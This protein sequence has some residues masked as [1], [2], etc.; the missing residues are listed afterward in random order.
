[1]RSSHLVLILIAALGVGCGSDVPP[2]VA[3]ASSQRTLVTGDVVG[4]LHP[5]RE[6]HVW[7]GI[8][9]AQPPVGELRWRAPLPPEPWEGVRN[10]ITAGNDCVQL[11]MTDPSKVTG[12]EDCLVLDVY[13]PKVAADAVPEGEDLKPVMVWI[14][15][16]GNSIGSAAVYDA[17]R[18][19]VEGDVIVVPIQYRLGL[20]GWL[21]HPALRASA[22]T[23]E[24]ASGNYGTMDTIRALEWVRDN[25]AAFGGDPNN[26]TVFGESA[27]GIDVFALLL[28]PRAKG[29]FHRAISQSG[30]LLSTPVAD[31]EAFADDDDPRSAGSGELFLQ[32][33]VHD[34]K[35][36][37]RDAAVAALAGMSHAEIESYLRAKSAEE[38]LAIFQNS[39]MG[40][41]YFVPQL[42][43]DGYVLSALDPLEALANPA[44]HNAV[45]TIAGTNR[46]ETKLFAMAGSPHVSTV[47]GVPTRVN[48]TLGFDLEG[49]YG[50]LLWKAQGADQPLTA[51]RQGGRND[52]WGYRFDWDEEG[53]I[54]WL[55]LS[56]LLGASHAVE[57]LFVFGF[58]DL[59]SWTDNV[60]AD[61]PSAER[62][63]AQMRSYWTHF[64]RTGTPGMGAGGTLPEWEAWGDGRYLLFDSAA[65]GGLRHTNDTV[66]VDSV[67]E[68]LAD[69]DRVRSAEERCALYRGLVTWSDAYTREQYDAFADGACQPWP[70]DL[71]ILGGG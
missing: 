63:S 41:M 62:L 44:K 1:M 56:K 55:D 54:L 51:M 33:L 19:A 65:G 45:P 67:V 6:A 27:G 61:P 8:P 57:M 34:G 20:F 49:E 43:R 42:F 35:A 71:A 68:R 3:D 46:E 16:G 23:P 29:L 28:S 30:V 17:S 47:F 26:V 14:H 66:T 59:G 21:T 40:G 12:D 39:M 11:D 48:D 58:T 52:L 38:L 36:A 2:P 4:Y 18:L 69:D 32:Y 24:D 15:G 37:D 64:A 53:K 10:A 9:F 31:A 5:D 22:A 60:F 13:A 25:A 50:G 70:L 7:K